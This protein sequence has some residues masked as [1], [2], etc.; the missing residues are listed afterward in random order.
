M[1][2]DDSILG[3]ERNLALSL[4]PEEEEQIVRLFLRSKD[5]NDDLNYLIAANAARGFKTIEHDEYGVPLEMLAELN[6]WS[7]IALFA[8]IGMINQKD[9]KDLGKL[10]VGRRVKELSEFAYVSGEKDFAANALFEMK[11]S[12]LGYDEEKNGSVEERINGINHDAKLQFLRSLYIPEIAK[13]S[14][15]GRGEYQRLF[16]PG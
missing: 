1:A 14:F 16:N 10:P 13:R 9:M 15:P 5:E 4:T 7:Q 8:G 3:L 6:F 11:K 12:R 2:I